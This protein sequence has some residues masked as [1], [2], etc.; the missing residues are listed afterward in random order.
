MSKRCCELSP[1]IV[2]F[3]FKLH[4]IMASTLRLRNVIDFFCQITM[5]KMNSKKAVCCYR[6]IKSIARLKVLRFFKIHLRSSIQNL[7]IGRL[8]MFFFIYSSLSVKKKKRKEKKR[9]TDVWFREQSLI[10][11]KCNSMMGCTS[12]NFNMCL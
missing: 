1:H 9:K 3:F 7:N 11:S 4:N 6:E 10:H 5:Y 2:G 12:K 8:H